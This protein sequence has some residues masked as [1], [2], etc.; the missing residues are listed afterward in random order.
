MFRLS[1]DAAITIDMLN[2]HNIQMTLAETATA[3]SVLPC[4]YR[5][6]EKLRRG[7]VPALAGRRA[8]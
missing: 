8:R 5:F 3:V 7:F 4:R 6:D 1:S 2:T